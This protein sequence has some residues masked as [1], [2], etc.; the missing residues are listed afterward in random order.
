M[1]TFVGNGFLDC[2]DGHCGYECALLSD[3]YV[4]EVQDLDGD[5]QDTND[6]RRYDG[7]LLE[8]CT[9]IYDIEDP[10]IVYGPGL[11]MLE[12]NVFLYNPIM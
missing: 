8:N 2:N 12:I 11:V 6:C 3:G 4:L 10:A 7:T 1:W 9:D 5:C